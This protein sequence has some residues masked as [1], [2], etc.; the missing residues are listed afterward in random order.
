MVSQEVQTT[1]LP[2]VANTFHTRKATCQSIVA[3]DVFHRDRDMSDI[4]G[5]SLLG[6]GVGG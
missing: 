3:P 5:S 6:G 4:L 2:G 1:E